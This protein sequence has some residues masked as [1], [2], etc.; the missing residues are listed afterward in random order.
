MVEME[1]SAYLQPKVKVKCFG[2]R[3]MSPICSSPKQE[4]TPLDEDIKEE[5]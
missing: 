3:R 5:W 2:V 1:K 4:T